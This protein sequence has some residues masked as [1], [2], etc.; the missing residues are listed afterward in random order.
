[1]FPQSKTNY[2]R[3]RLHGL[4]Y[5]LAAAIAAS[6]VI[7]PVAVQT[8]TEKAE[9]DETA[10]VAKSDPVMAA[11]MRK[12]QAELPGFAVGDLLRHDLSV[13]EW[14]ISA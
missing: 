5:F 3:R 1:M 4:S 14:S 7:N 2:A 8:V 13:R 10:I 11:A 9:H 12:A 6:L